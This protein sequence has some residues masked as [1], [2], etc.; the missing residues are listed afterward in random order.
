MNY[1]INLGIWKNVFCIPSVIVDR[2]IKLAGENDIK[3]LLYLLRNAD[4]AFSSE[5]LGEQLGIDPE[6]AEESVNFWIKREVLSI[7]TLGNLAPSDSKTE[8][9]IKKTVVAENASGGA[10][11][12]TENTFAPASSLAESV[13]RKVNLERT[14]DFPPVE[15]AQTVRNNANADFLFKQCEKLYGRPL[16]HN[17]QNTVMVIL[18]DTCLPAEVCL[19]LINYCFS[20]GKATPAYMRKTALEWSESEITTI[21]KAEERVARLNTFNGAVGRFKKMFEVTSSFSKQQEEMIDKWVNVY[22]LSDEM[23]EEAYQL[24]LNGAGKL[25]FPYMNKI[26]EDWNSKGYKNV[27]QIRSE[28]SSKAK[29]ETAESSFDI[30]EI[31]K[32]I[33]NKYM[34]SGENE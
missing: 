5:E 14:P 13:V 3:V 23:I 24:T 26:L 10:T 12:K 28:K 6:Q 29:K 16:K 34:N 1:K 22:G 4:E 7:D 21:E 18:E 31:E 19:I 33:N 32:M 25:S 2:Y 20:V 30:A 27:E 11:A 15:I 17:E 9:N 8:I